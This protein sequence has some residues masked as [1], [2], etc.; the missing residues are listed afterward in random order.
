MTSLKKINMYIYKKITICTM[1]GPNSI[2]YQIHYVLNAL[3][4]TSTT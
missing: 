1:V 2:K 3:L 4:W